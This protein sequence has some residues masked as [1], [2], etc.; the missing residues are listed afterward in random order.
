[1]PLKHGCVI[2]SFRRVCPYMCI[3]NYLNQ[4][5]ILGTGVRLWKVYLQVP[6]V[7]NAPDLKTAVRT[8][9]RTLNGVES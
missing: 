8:T 3:S 5:C 6:G 7:A 2:E 4:K 1:M 9:L